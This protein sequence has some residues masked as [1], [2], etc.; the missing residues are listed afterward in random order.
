MPTAA[1]P[2]TRR[3]HL[4]MLRLST[5]KLRVLGKA[6]SFGTAGRCWRNDRSE[7]RRHEKNLA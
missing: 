2:K 6:L 7:R 1:K 3:F 4:W 5:D